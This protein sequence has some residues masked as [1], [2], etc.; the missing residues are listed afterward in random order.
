[1]LIKNI[2]GNKKNSNGFIYPQYDNNCISNIPNA[3]LNAFDVKSQKTKSPL[4]AAVKETESKKITKVVLLVIDGFGFNQFLNH[5]KENRFLANL[6]NR[7]KVFPLTSVFP[8]QTTNALTTLNTGLETQE[9]GLFEYF[10]YLKEVGKIVNAL[11]FESIGS[12]RRN[13]LA[14]EGFDPTIL[15]KG[16]TIHRTL[17]ENGVNTFTHI[18]VSNAHN[19]CSKLIFEGSTIIPSLK[20]S[21]L[22]VNLRKT[23]EK[24]AGKAYSFVHIDSLDTIAHE[25]GPLSYEYSAE[26]SAICY[27]LNKELAEKIDPKIAKETLILMIADHGGVNV[28]PEEMVYLNRFPRVIENLQCGKDGKHISPVGSRGNFFFVLKME[29]WGKHGTCFPK[30]S[31]IKHKLLKLTRQPKWACLEGET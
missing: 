20:T 17:T 15:F 22:I 31:A 9:H 24:N 3:I 26:L 10:I 6:T 5:Y 29:N 19:V 1:M 27:L 11:R 7:G 18:H 23:L 13:K 12:N 16:K 14:E 2:E 4:E 8:S 21:D 25:Y 28:V 30:K